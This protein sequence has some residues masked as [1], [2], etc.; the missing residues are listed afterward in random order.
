MLVK[1]YLVGLI[2]L[3]GGLAYS[4]PDV[5]ALV[6]SP[7]VFAAEQASMICY[8]TFRKNNYPGLAVAVS[9]GGEVIFSEGWGYADIETKKSIDPDKSM[10]RVGS[11]SKT[12]TAA[13]LQLLVQEGE[14]DLDADISN[15]V[16]YFPKKR[17]DL[18][19]SQVAGHIAG[20]RHYNGPLEM[21]NNKYYPTVKEGMEIFMNDSLLYEPGEKFSYSSYGWNL[22]SAIV[23]E[24]SDTPFLDYMQAQVFDRFGMDQ[25]AA[26]IRSDLPADLVSFYIHNM[27]GNNVTAPSVDNSYKWAGG[28]F[29][30]TATDILKFSHQMHHH[31][32]IDGDLLDKFQTPLILNNGKQTNYGL[33]WASNTDKKGRR[34][35]GHSGGSVG[36]TSMYL[37]YPDHDLTVVTLVNLSSA[38]MDQLAWIVAEQFL[39]ISKDE[40]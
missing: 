19:V 31:E 38:R 36:G 34:W 23:E 20:V 2:C 28:G 33:G 32:A 14:V 39:S 11:I 40:E 22:I 29:I 12:L 16:D 30:A 27:V 17:Y 9:K 13:G 35:V 37:F 25:T 6:D 1:N 7:E 15:Y 21:L 3:I 10:F 18:S 4:Q 5:D 8:K 26:E 24:A